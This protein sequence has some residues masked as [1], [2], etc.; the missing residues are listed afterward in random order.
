MMKVY[1]IT[2]PKY[3]KDLSG[4][5]ARRFGGRWNSQGINMLYTSSSI[6]LSFLEILVHTDRKYLRK[7]YSIIE[8]E[9]D[10]SNGMTVGSAELSGNWNTYPMGEETQYLGDWFVTKGTHFWMSVPSVVVP[11]EKNYLINPSHKDFKEG[12]KILNVFEFFPDGRLS[13]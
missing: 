1:R 10:A 8:L 2:S 5:G 11:F 7:V 3:A 4:E 13:N 9:V 6:A 12:V